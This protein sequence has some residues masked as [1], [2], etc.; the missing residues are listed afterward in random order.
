M[1]Q[2]FMPKNQQY[3]LIE[4]AENCTA[5][6]KLT[7]INMGICIIRVW[8]IHLQHKIRV[9]SWAKQPQQTNF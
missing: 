1:T 7:I 4:D 5:G 6:L 8:M 3:N 9:N 2:G